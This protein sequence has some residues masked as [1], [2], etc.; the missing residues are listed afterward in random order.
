MVQP[1][2]RI[3]LQY[4]LETVMSRLVEVYNLVCRAYSE[5]VTK[6]PTN[7][8]FNFDAKKMEAKAFSTSFLILNQIMSELKKTPQDLE[9][10]PPRYF[11]EMPNSE[12]RSNLLNAC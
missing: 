6:S 11:R 4:T 7:N 12:E 2:K 5:M 10:Y 9:I 8:Q 3:T 1:Q